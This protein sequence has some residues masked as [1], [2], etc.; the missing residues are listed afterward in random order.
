NGSYIILAIPGGNTNGTF[1][2]SPV[3]V[4]NLALVETRAG[5]QH[6]FQV[7]D[8][9][10]G[11]PISGAD[12]KFTYQRNYDRPI[13]NKNLVSDAMGMVSVPL[14]VG[15]WNNTSIL[16]STSEEEAQF[17]R[18]NIYAQQDPTRNETEYSCF[19]F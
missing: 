5:T 6:N 7:I 2:Y 18:F 12:L 17:E 1:A 16:V 9:H 19:L 4:T 11:R 3:Q 8:R 14:S 10:T 15:S 13:L